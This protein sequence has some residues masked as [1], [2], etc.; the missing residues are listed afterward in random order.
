MATD[1]L[2][3]NWIERQQ[4]VLITGTGKTWLACA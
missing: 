4:N 1:L 2:T 3:C